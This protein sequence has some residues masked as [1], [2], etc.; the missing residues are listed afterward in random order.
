M[1]GELGLRARKKRE[2]RQRIAD[3]ATLLFVTRGFESVTVADIAA[4][5]DVSRV[6]VFNYFPRKEDMFF[7]RQDEAIAVFTAAVRDR[8]PGESVLAALR[9]MLLDLAD[10]RHPLSGLRDGIEPFL[11]TVTHSPTLLAASREN[12]E[13]LERAL[14]E[15][16]A[17]DVEADPADLAP[18]LI[19]SGVLAAYRLGYRYAT[20]GVLAGESADALHP[21]YRDLVDTAFDVLTHGVGDYGCR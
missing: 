16:I 5:A 11:R 3:V 19:A 13:A 15:T 18:T 12:Q 20:E 9:R 17:R 4:A 8:P 2:T 7:D 6:T 1:D 14:A 21:R 10:R